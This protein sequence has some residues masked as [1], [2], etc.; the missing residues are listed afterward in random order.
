ME[1]EVVFKLDLPKPLCGSFSGLPPINQVTCKCLICHYCLPPSLRYFDNM[2][3][4]T[5][6]KFLQASSHE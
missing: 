5:L 6:V 4:I 2:C 1:N 3:M